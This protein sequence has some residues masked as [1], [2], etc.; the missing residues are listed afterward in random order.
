MPQSS[1]VIRKIVERDGRFMVS[2]PNHSGYFKVADGKQQDALIARIRAAAESG[3]T[4][5]FTFDKDFNII[6]IA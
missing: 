2:F 6:D 5:D 4:L 1:G 3:V